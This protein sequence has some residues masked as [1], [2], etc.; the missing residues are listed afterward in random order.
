MFPSRPP[1]SCGR[2]ERP[3]QPGLLFAFSPPAHRTP[4]MTNSIKSPHPHSARSAGPAATPPPTTPSPSCSGWPS[5][6]SR[7]EGH[8]SARPGRPRPASAPTSPPHLCRPP[9]DHGRER[10]GG[11][12]G[13][14]AVCSCEADPHARRK[15]P[16]A[17]ARPAAQPAGETLYYPRTSPRGLSGRAVPRRRDHSPTKLPGHESIFYS[18]RHTEPS[19]SIGEAR[20]T[21]TIQVTTGP[22]DAGLSQYDSDSTVALNCRDATQRDM[23]RCNLRPWHGRG[24]G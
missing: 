11:Y 24:L 18:S 15:A 7:T 12:V 23:V 17:P 2:S 3:R 8:A 21:V 20:K 13:E 1:R 22:D 9:R 6:P 4:H 5:S 19:P 16:A 10:G 14:F